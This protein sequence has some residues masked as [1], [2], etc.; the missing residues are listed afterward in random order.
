MGSHSLTRTAIAALATAGVAAAQNDECATAIALSFGVPT[1]F[2]T[3]VG[4]LSA[5]AWTCDPSTAPDLWYTV[6]APGAG[7]I[8]VDICGSSFDTML[9]VFTGTCGNLTYLICSDDACGLSSR[10][11]FGVTTGTTYTFRVGGFGTAMGIGNVTATYTMGAGGN[12]DCTGA[13][14]LTL[15]A[16]IVFDT[17]SASTSAP[18]WTC[19][20]NGGPDLWYSYTAT[21]NGELRVSTC[22]SSYDTALE[23]FSGNC[24]NPALIACNDDVCAQQAQVTWTATSGTSYLIRVG[25]YNGLSGLGTVLLEVPPPAGV[26][27]V[28]NVA[29]TWIDISGTGTALGLDDD[30]E[31][32]IL[33]TLGNSLLPAGVARVG[34]NGGVR[35]GGVGTNMIAVNTAIPNGLVF[36]GD[37]TLLPFWDDVNT[38]LGTVG[39]IYW[40]ETQGRLIIQWADVG[41]YNGAATDR[42]SFQIQVPATGAYFAQ[43]LYQDVS[44]ARANNGGSATIGY[45]AGGVENDVQWSFNQAGAVMDGT[46]LTLLPIG[47]GG[48][49]TNFC[50]ANANSTGQTGR[51]AGSGSASVAANGLTLSADQ[52]PN[53]AF[54]FFLTSTTQSFVAN[55]AGSQGNLCLGGS[56]GRYVGAG[57]IKNTGATGAFSLALDLTQTPTPTGFVSVTVGQTRYFQAWHR[58]VAAG[59]ATSNFTNGLAVT[60]Q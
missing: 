30:E 43:F 41:F 59:A 4:T 51:I 35:F 42:A 33:T 54:G 23:V 38:A 34:S 48:V 10:V 20:G 45:Q 49:G 29:G 6:T 11:Q 55:P 21:A 28:S 27:L 52:L 2:D 40:Q 46:V 57:Q 3:S 7:S 25:G 13:T 53:N 50:V 24:G 9:E 5:P 22:G 39:D 14:P 19:A 58:D 56:I 60:F 26:E 44:G 8:T 31:I 32:D 18:N 15:N 12:D 1:L 36:A 16:P 37:Q 17:L 47:A